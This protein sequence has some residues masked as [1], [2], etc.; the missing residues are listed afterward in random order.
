MRGTLG[1]ANQV[2]I[3]CNLGN[4]HGHQQVPTS[5]ATN[6]ASRAQ[7]INDPYERR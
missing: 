3:T 7:P 4:S 1:L 2:K 6:E 5:P